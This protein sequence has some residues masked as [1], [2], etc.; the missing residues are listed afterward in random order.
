MVQNRAFGI[1]VGGRWAIHSFLFFAARP[2]LADF[3]MPINK[4]YLEK[5]RRQIMAWELVKLANSERKVSI[6]KELEALRQ[7]LA[8]NQR[9][10]EKLERNWQQKEETFKKVKR[11]GEKREKGENRE[12]VEDKERGSNRNRER[13]NGMSNC[14]WIW[15]NRINGGRINPTKRVIDLPGEEG[16]KVIKGIK[17]ICK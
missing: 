17:W 4:I 7:Q 3:L 15:K 11:A 16:T 6:Q 13:H 9:E 2:I 12:R 10:M 5:L 14:E 1:K 8:D